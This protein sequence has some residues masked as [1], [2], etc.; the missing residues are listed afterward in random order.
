MARLRLV[1]TNR[2]DYRDS[3]ISEHETVVVLFLTGFKQ[4]TIPRQVFSGLSEQISPTILAVA[5]ILVTF[6]IF[7]LAMIELLRRRS[8]RLK[9]DYAELGQEFD[10]GLQL[11]RSDFK[12]CTAE[13]KHLLVTP[14]TSLQRRGPG[15]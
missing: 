12:R 6:S 8:E 1:K 14:K 7:L 2:G 10:N 15:P 9:G 13:H 3:R 11:C 4:R 5:T